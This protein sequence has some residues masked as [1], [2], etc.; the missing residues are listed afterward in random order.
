M[1]TLLCMEYSNITIVME[2]LAIHGMTTTMMKMVVRD[3]AKH[4][5][6]NKR[7]LRHRLK[8]GDTTGILLRTPPKRAGT[9][10]WMEFVM[11]KQQG[12]D[13]M[14]EYKSTPVGPQTNNQVASLSSSILDQAVFID[15][16]TDVAAPCFPKRLLRCVL[17]CLRHWIPLSSS[18]I[19]NRSK[20]R[21]VR[22]PMAFVGEDS[23]IHHERQRREVR[24]SDL[25]EGRHASRS[26]SKAVAY[27]L[28]T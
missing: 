25:S 11:T 7:E 13:G 27:R 24:T 10:D 3:R 8:W 1:R 2:I 18:G 14:C 23:K 20:H 15:N 9:A 17:P 6:G 16:G 22:T 28:R 5:L 21:F 12:S 19:D 4:T 26:Y